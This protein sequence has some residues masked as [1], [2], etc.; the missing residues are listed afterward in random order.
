MSQT[1]QTTIKTTRESLERLR[2]YAKFG[3]S[4]DKV[5]NHV[6]DIADNKKREEHEV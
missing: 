6:L 2:P 1:G 4:W 3:D 5:L